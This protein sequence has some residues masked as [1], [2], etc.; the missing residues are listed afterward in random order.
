MIPHDLPE[1]T[2]TGT[3]GLLLFI[4]AAGLVHLV[5]EEIKQRRARRGGE[6]L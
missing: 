4:V 1:I 6:R 5:R 2:D 3:L